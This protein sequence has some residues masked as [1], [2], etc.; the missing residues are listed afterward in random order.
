MWHFSFSPSPSPKPVSYGFT[1]WKLNSVWCCFSVN[2][3]NDFSLPDL[4]K[5]TLAY[6]LQQTSHTNTEWWQP[7]HRVE[8]RTAGASHFTTHWGKWLWGSH[9]WSRVLSKQPLLWCSSV[10]QDVV[11]KREMTICDPCLDGR[12]YASMYSMYLLIWQ[13]LNWLIVLSQISGLKSWNLCFK[14]WTTCC[15]PFTKL[16]VIVNFK[17]K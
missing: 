13:R 5:H 17:K 8:E 14:S 10:C 2:S 7:T 1:S 11:S 4:F 12:V 9:N 15:A 16:S 3:S 6:N